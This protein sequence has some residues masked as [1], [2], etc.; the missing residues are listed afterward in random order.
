[1]D[2]LEG[3]EKFFLVIADVLCEV[4]DKANMIRLDSGTLN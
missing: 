1:M 2:H 4:S 3:I